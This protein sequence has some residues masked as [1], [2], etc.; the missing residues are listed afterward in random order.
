ML[1]YFRKAVDEARQNVCE[2]FI[3]DMMTC[4]RNEGFKLEHVLMALIV[5]TSD[6]SI[7]TWQT[8]NTLLRQAVDE[9]KKPNK[10]DRDI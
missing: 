5:Y 9:L 10:E 2:E 7:P 3:K 8:V 4:L 1:Q 6:S